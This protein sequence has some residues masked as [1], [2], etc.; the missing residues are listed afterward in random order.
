MATIPQTQANGFLGKNGATIKP[1]AI[2]TV[3][4]KRENHM[5]SICTKTPVDQSAWSAIQLLSE[6]DKKYI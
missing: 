2:A 3:P 6:V 5:A 4:Q 1:M